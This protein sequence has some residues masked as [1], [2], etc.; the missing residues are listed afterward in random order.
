M[1]GQGMF[2]ELRIHRAI[3]FTET[4]EIQSES[5]IT[6]LL[7]KKNHDEKIK[8]GKLNYKEF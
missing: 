5:I 2:A 6:L 4:P 8:L 1:I 7:S 3:S